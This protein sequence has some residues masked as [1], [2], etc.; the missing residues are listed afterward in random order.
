MSN[1]AIKSVVFDKLSGINGTIILYFSDNVLSKWDPLVEVA[2]DALNNKFHPFAYNE[3]KKNIYK[4]EKLGRE[5]QKA[6]RAEINDRN[7]L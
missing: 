6:M 7:K 4:L 3:S 1:A 2:L 5:L